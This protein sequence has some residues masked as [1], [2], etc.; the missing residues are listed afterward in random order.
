MSLYDLCEE[1]VFENIFL[2]VKMKRY[3]E[4]S[5]PDFAR[6]SQAL[7]EPHKKKSYPTITE[8][9][10]FLKR[11]ICRK[12]TGEYNDSEEVA[13]VI[14]DSEEYW[15]NYRNKHDQINEFKKLLEQA[16]VKL[17][18]LMSLF[19]HLKELEKIQI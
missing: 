2:E 3:Q 10:T 5:V 15:K 11:V 6:I 16:K 9:T 12:L 18:Q 8:I 7:V 19:E 4:I 14:C 13:K 17:I 1:E